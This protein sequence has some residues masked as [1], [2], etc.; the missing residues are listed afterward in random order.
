MPVLVICKIHYQRVIQHK[1]LLLLLLFFVLFCF[2]FVCFFGGG[3]SGFFE[4]KAK[5]LGS[6]SFDLA[7]FSVPLKCLP[8]LSAS[9]IMIG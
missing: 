3:G 9:F 5:V 2:V 1:F 8:S 6:D 4:A 7:S